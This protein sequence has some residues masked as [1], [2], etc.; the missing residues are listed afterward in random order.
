MIL[1]YDRATAMLALAL[2]LQPHVRAAL[3]AELA[4]LTSGEHDLTDWTD[5]LIIE[6]GDAEEAIALEAG[7]SPFVS[8][9]SGARHGEPEFEPG[10]DLLTFRGGV[11]R[12]VFYEGSD[13]NYYLSE[14]QKIG[15][16]LPLENVAP[17][18]V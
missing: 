10:F 15:D 4:L 17:P 16:Y 8:S 14:R 5:I 12:L 6:S 11:Y 2:D 7:F 18:G 9:L 1:I 13:R 3:E